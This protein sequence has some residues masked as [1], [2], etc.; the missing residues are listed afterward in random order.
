MSRF[1]N[2][3]GS[4]EAQTKRPKKRKR[5]EAHDP[6]KAK[7]QKLLQGRT[8]LPIWPRAE[9]IRESLSGEKDILI[10]TGETGSGKSTQVPQFLLEAKWCTGKIAVTQPR[11]VAA[12]TLARR[13]AE[14]MGSPLGS[15]SPAS[16]V[17][18]SVRFDDNTSPGTR[19][20]YLTE[21]MLL[22]ELLREPKLGQYSCVVVDEVHERS[23]DVDLILGFLKQLVRERREKGKILKVVVMSATADVES[24]GEFFA[25]GDDE[26]CGKDESDQEKDAETRGGEGAEDSFE[27]FE[28]AEPQQENNVLPDR[29]ARCHVEGR[30]YPVKLHYASGP[31][32]DVID[33]AL[34]QIFQI[35]CKEPMPGDILVFLTGQ[36]AITGLQRL[37]E[38][39]ASSLT[40]DFPKM[41]VLPLYAALPQHAQQRIFERAPPNTRKVILSTNIAETSVTVPGV[42]FV[43]DTGK[44]KIKQ[45]RPRLG[46]ESLLI[47]PISRSSADQ[48]KGRAGR[49]APGQCFRLFTEAEYKSL[50][51]QTKPEIL[52]CDLTG[53]VLKMK[54][55]GIEDVFGFPFLTPPSQEAMGRSLMQLHQLGCIN[56]AGKIT[57]I[58]R[59]VARLP[60]PPPLGRVILESAK[61]ERDCLLE[62]IDVV[63]GLDVES[64]WL[65][66][67][68]EEAREK[69]MEARSQLFSRRG[70][71]ITLLN[72]I[73]TYADENS[74]RKR[75]AT[76]HMISHRA[77]QNVMEVRKQLRVLTK[78][79]L[80]KPTIRQTVS[81]ECQDAVLKCF[82]RGFSGN[83]ARLCPDK[84]YKTFGGKQQ[85]VAIHPSSVLY[86]VKREAIMF[87]DFTFT[88]KPWARKVSAVELRWLEEVEYLMGGDG[89]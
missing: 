89:S 5:E 8:A 77:M 88:T 25:R 48:R 13:V 81:E 47:K 11:R 17:G 30:Q 87:N 21:G 14:E 72:A 82:L 43:I 41:L 53:A 9:E 36:E 34:Q 68:T 54:A 28:D 62:V 12:I 59:K 79:L 74:D 10:L 49:E 56:D 55:R 71:H 45:F 35:H 58:G 50:E 23:V 32:E 20:K 57:E 78:S 40:T 7:K 52:H 67:E 6:Y 33:A 27:G 15:A 51:Q 3:D 64:I 76:D 22:Q 16:K 63:A 39:F 75:W 73:R 2:L 42:R 66:A 29:I 18:Y 65:P 61:P 85:Q 80:E 24:L 86:G 84:S 69:A 46:I 26:V 37:V 70:D 4:I 44:A 83:V 31:T 38:E 1:K 60:L 19:I